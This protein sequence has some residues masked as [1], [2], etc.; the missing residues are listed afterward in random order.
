[1][2]IIQRFD[3]SCS[4][5]A[6]SASHRQVIIVC[7]IG[8]GAPRDS[9]PKGANRLVDKINLISGWTSVQAR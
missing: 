2:R 6:L 7:T 5:T 9:F 4:I 3:V 8:D 1:M